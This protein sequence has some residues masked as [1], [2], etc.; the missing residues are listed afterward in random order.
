MKKSQ[1]SATQ[2]AAAQPEIAEQTPRI[3]VSTKTSTEAMLEIDEDSKMSRKE[4][5]SRQL[6]NQVLAKRIE[7][8]LVTDAEQEKVAV[9]VEEEKRRGAYQP[10]R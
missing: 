9:S 2:F 1:P 6:A 8:A 5:L 3:W 10:K 7:N 4:S